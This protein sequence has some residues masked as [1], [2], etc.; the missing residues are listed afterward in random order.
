MT[1]FRA[2]PGFTWVFVLRH[3]F[4]GAE[5][6]EEG[7]GPDGLRPGVAGDDDGGQPAEARAAA[8]LSARQDRE[9]MENLRLHKESCRIQMEN[10]QMMQQTQ[11]TTNML[12]AAFMKMNPDML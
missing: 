12:L 10:S 2:L 9:R 4:H 8:E 6:E 3:I 11:Q 7:E 1:C 5:G